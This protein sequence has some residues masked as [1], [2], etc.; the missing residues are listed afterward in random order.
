MNLGRIRMFIHKLDPKKES[1]EKEYE[2][3]NHETFEEGLIS[4]IDVDRECPHGMDEYIQD[5]DLERE[6]ENISELDA[7]VAG[8]VIEV[9]ADF[10][11]QSS[12]DYYGEWDSECWFENVKHRKLTKEQTLMF[13][14]EEIEPELIPLTKSKQK[15]PKQI[16][17]DKKT[18]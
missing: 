15:K 13:T 16:P 6:I 14:G 2:I 1:W 10:H 12:C 9:V 17:L 11:E 7:Y 8:D 3:L 5:A 4:D 18:N